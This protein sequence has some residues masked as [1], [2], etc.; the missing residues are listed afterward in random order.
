MTPKERLSV[1]QYLFGESI[2]DE[3]DDLADG[4]EPDEAIGMTAIADSAADAGAKLFTAKGCYNCH[5]LGEISGSA[6]FA[7]ELYALADKQLEK[8]EFGAVPIPHTLEDYIT[9]KLQAPR[10]FADNLKMPFFGFDPKDV[11]RIAT[12]LSSFSY[13]IP[14]SYTKKEAPPAQDIAGQMGQI[15]QKYN[16][17]SCHQ[18]NGR[19]GSLAPELSMEGS[20]VQ[21]QWL[22][23]Y[24]QKPYAIRPFLEQRMPRFNLSDAEI[25]V[26]SSFAALVWRDDRIDNLAVLNNGDPMKGE[27]LY[28]LKGCQTCHAIGTQGGYYGPALDNVGRRLQ[29]AWIMARL[30]TVHDFVDDAKEPALAIPAEERPDLLAY[31]ITLVGEKQQ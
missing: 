30:D 10:I 20:Q 31:L 7:P 13:T 23:D 3:E 15:V 19:G 5:R 16:C 26:I 18:L 6:N 25:Q 2:L 17:L 27:E 8:I 9:T 21:G 28:A 29:P 24:L 14:A 22:Q 11:G 12:A 4:N 1:V